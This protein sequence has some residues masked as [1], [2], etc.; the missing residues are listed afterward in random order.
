VIRALLVDGVGNAVI[1]EDDSPWPPTRILV[2]LHQFLKT[3]D[4]MFDEMPVYRLRG[5]LDAPPIRH[6]SLLAKEEI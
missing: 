2:G 5:F 4:E 6:I 1:H 3:A